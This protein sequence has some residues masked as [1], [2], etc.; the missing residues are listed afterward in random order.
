MPSQAWATIARRKKSEREGSARNGRTPEQ[1]AEYERCSNGAD[2]C[3]HWM[4][5]YAKIEDPQVPGWIA[6]D[7]WPAQEDVVRKLFA[8]QKVVALKSRQIGITWIAVAVGL[9]KMIFEPG[10]A[11]GL[12]SRRDDEAVTLLRDR[13]RGMHAQLPAWLRA[14]PGDRDNDHH[15]RLANRSSAR[16]FPTGVGDSYTLSYV[17]YDE[18][19]LCDTLGESLSA[20]EPTI[21]DGGTIFVISKAVKGRPASPFKMI[22][23]GAPDNGWCPVFLP[24]H[25]R[26]ERDEA[27]YEARKK[28]SLS[29]YG[30]LDS[31]YENYPATAAEA[32]AE[33]DAS[34]RYAADWIA[35]CVTD[36]PRL[37]AADAQGMPPVA[38]LRVYRAPVPGRRY[39][40][41]ADPAEGNPASDNSAFVVLD[42]DSW[43]E[44]AS[45][46]GRIQIEPF[47]KAIND[48]GRWYNRASI[49]C[50]RNNHGHAV[51]VWLR[52][53][54][55]LS[56]MTG[57]D[58][59]PGYLTS[60]KSKVLR[61]DTLAAALHDKDVTIHSLSI[62]DELESI[63]GT[64]LKAPAG[65][66]DDEAD[67]FG[68]A[69]LAAR[70]PRTV[71]G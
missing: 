19:D 48:V 30:N 26:P 9:W 71:L 66:T 42:R 41:G 59:K 28:E 22:Y 50:E 37:T 45:I 33:P 61:G 35:Q 39:V 1:Q 64:T 15:W 69:L 31:L 52:G 56:L 54:S 17:V 38:G 4:H 21:N 49:L 67:A 47:S 62:A 29:T 57:D 60:A 27:F 12:S 40:I 10:T 68:L 70:K 5:Q 63:D 16:A 2:G 14:A 18:A 58:G 3:I 8:N 25:V 20:L 65:R 24:W 11:V 53:N 44:V 51:L 7:L 32:L 36:A 43:E 46:K 34:K 55:Q 13:M 23:K 6:F